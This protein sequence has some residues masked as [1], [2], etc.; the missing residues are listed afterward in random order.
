MK[1]LLLASDGKFL[2]SKGLGLI[3]IPK[4]QMEIAYVTTASKGGTK[5]LNYV[6]QSKQVM[7]ERGYNFEEVD[8]E[9]KTEKE[10]EAIFKNKNIIYVAGGNTFYLLKIV[11]ESG[12]DKV[13]EG[14][15]EKGVVYVGVSAGAYIA[16]P[17]ID[18]ST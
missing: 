18:V 3:G 15:I 11:K 17:T 2:F 5:S 1:K 13:V 16:C 9:G 12:F 10:L 7:W 8:I 4:K 6:E 14:L